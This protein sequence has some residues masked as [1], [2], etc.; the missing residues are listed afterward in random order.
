MACKGSAV[1]I[2]YAPPL[3]LLCQVQHFAFSIGSKSF[4]LPPTLTS[5]FISF[6]VFAVFQVLLVKKSFVPILLELSLV[7]SPW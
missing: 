5:V 6:V 4:L 7:V 1:R 2:R 3:L